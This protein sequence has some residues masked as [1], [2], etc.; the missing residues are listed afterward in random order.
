MNGI[1]YQ[2]EGNMRIMR[3]ERSIGDATSEDKHQCKLGRIGLRGGGIDVGMEPSTQPPG[4]L[5]STARITTYPCVMNAKKKRLFVFCDGTWQDGVNNSTPLTN[6][7]TLARCLAPYDEDG[8]LQIAYYDSGVGNATSLPAQLIDAATG[9]GISAKIR[10]A[11]SFLSHNYNFRTFSDE[12]VFVGFSRGAF[13][14]QCLAS[15]ISQ[16]GLLEKQHLY[17]LRGLFTTWANQ[18]VKGGVDVLDETMK[19]MKG[20]LKEPRPRPL[21]FVGH[22]IP[23]RV[24]HAFQALALDETRRKFKPRV[25][26]AR[27]QDSA[28]Q[29]ENNAKSADRNTNPNQESSEISQCWFLGSHGDVGGNGDAALGAVSLLWMVGKLHDK[30]GVSFIKSEIEK[31]L[32]HRF[33]DWRVSVNRLFRSFHDARNLST[34]QHSG[35]AKRQAWYWLFL[36]WKSRSSY[37]GM[38]TTVPIEVHFT[39]RLGMAANDNACDPLENWE[40]SWLEESDRTNV[41]QWHSRDASRLLDEHPLDHLQSKEYALLYQW[42]SPDRNVI[43]DRAK[44]AKVEAPNT[45]EGLQGYADFL[46][47]V[48][49]FEQEGGKWRL[50]PTLMYPRT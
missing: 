12:I 50:A 40:T 1:R 30:V 24:Q 47:R 5:P 29:E 45:E 13:A 8:Y 37:L 7:A 4:R 34:M 36:G 20:V 2:Y 18:K 41:V 35:H 46:K 43:T 22:E 21:E 6:V 14:V 31:H 38:S 28:V 9:R 44:F 27:K 3:I 15:F 17:Y 42:S 19:E 26:T 25:W 10:N 49:K 39:V 32:K 33:L 48:M 16:T 11:Y 23:N